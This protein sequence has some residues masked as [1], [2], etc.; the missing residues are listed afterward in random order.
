MKADTSSRS[1]LRSPAGVTA[2]VC[3]LG[4][5]GYAAWVFSSYFNPEFDALVSSGGLILL[6]LLVA[7]FG[8]FIV[9][10]R[11]Y[12]RTLRWAWLM[13]S[14]GALCNV[15]AEGIWLIYSQVLHIDPYP[16]PADVFYTL[17]YP[18]TLIGI[19]IFTFV[20]VPRQER[21]VLWLD[22]VIIITFYGMVTW[23]HIFTSPLF[24]PKGSWE[25]FWAVTYPIGDLLILTTIIAV[26][27]RDLTRVV[28]KILSLMALAMLFLVVA[29]AF[30]AYFH[31]RGVEDHL[32]ILTIL[33]LSAAVTQMFA[34]S[35]LIA[36]GPEL[37]NDPPARFSEL[38]ELLRPALPYLA[39]IIG[40]ALLAIAIYANPNLDRRLIGYLVGAYALV[41][42]V[43]LRQYLV[44]KENVRLA[45][46]M[47]RIAWTD[48]LTGVYT[49]HFFNEMLPREMERAQRYHYQLSVLLLDIDGFKKYNDTY[50]HLKGDL[51]L[52]TV[53]RLFSG[54][55]RTSDTIA[56]FGGDEFTVILPETNRRKA[57]AIAGRIKEAVGGQSF[58]NTR[59]SVSIGVACLRPGLTP[60]QL[61]DEADKD[62]Y[63][64]KNS[65][66]SLEQPAEK[67]SVPVPLFSSREEESARR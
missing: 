19:L 53:A 27:Q 32:E 26:S 54:Q 36:S 17:Y 39:I 25:Q 15:F 21:L 34:T 6:H 64:R 45:Q 24:A 66:K 50:G 16:S 14:L 60:E 55:L 20:F 58:E 65:T 48:S 31:V 1:L 18:L 57:L 38:R 59:L 3:T 12:G 4:V 67:I 52:K 51:V 61:L 8:L 47:R 40:L 9:L 7:F 30:F 41:A 13:L 49:R 56:R 33:W 11:G 46:T 43:L 23:Y 62:M 29:D 22:L 63:R 44:L 28:R 10:N 5:I 35:R 42:I 37:L 2:I